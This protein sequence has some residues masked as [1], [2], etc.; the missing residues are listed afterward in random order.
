MRETELDFLIYQQNLREERIQELVNDLK[1]TII[2]YFENEKKIKGLVINYPVP[3]FEADHIRKH[4]PFPVVVR[5]RET[6][7]WHRV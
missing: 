7:E 5:H 1:H 4:T 3:K 6:G 2:L